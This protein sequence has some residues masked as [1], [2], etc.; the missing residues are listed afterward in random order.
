M[1]HQE[2]EIVVNHREQLAYLLSEAAEIEH[3]LMCCYLYASFSLKRHIDEGVTA[4]ELEAINRWRITLNE[5]AREE[6]VHLALVSNLCTAIG[7][8]PHLMRPNLPVASGYHPSGISLSLSRLDEA[9]IDHFVYM[10]RPEGVQLPD[11][12]GYAKGDYERPTLP[13]RLM[14]NAQDYATVGHLYR[15]ILDGC[16][17]LCATLGEQKLFCGDPRGQVDQK[18]FALDGLFAITDLASAERA[19]QL[20][21]TQGEGASVSSS[22]GHYARFVQLQREYQELR[23]ARPDFDPARPVARNPVMRKPPSPEDRVYIDD[24]AAAR[25][26]DFANALYT[27]IVRLL[28]RVFGTVEE[29]EAER[30]MLAGLTVDL[31]HA[32]TVTSNVLTKMP[33]SAAHPG[34]RAGITFAISRSLDTLPQHEAARRLF[35]ERAHELTARCELLATEVSADLAPVADRLRRLR[36]RLSASPVSAPVPQQIST[37]ISLPI[38]AEPTV[39]GEDGIER[40]TGKRITLAFEA[41]R[42]IHSRH[43]V[44][45]GPDVFL[46]NVPGAWIHPDAASADTVVAIAQM[47]PSGAITYERTDGEPNERVPL[48]NVARVREN[49][50]YAFTADL[51]LDGREP[52][53]RATLCRCG[54]SQNKPFCD[55]SHNGIKFSATGEPAT[56]STEPLAERGGALAVS[57]QPNGPLFVTGNLEICAGTGRILHRVTSA[58]LCRCGGS[59]KKP[60]CDG[61]HA[62]IGFEAD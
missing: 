58:K 3:G 14:P 22:A 36:D 6:M 18:I 34:V 7:M 46:A 57:P 60:F 62:R 50:P 39:K 20:I 28:G 49:G 10:E 2:P 16:R 32:M 52:M 19:I 17:S 51:Q 13:G 12:E 31:M 23:K 40:V 37:Q 26:L 45:N 1:N 42:C 29:S 56:I 27:M 41:K 33:A 44:L 21:L 53:I 38:T 4:L 59:A 5:V 8:A 24:A 55:G 61:T 25:V 11:G 48:V 47:C 54:A 15:G 43:C 30:R 9:T 35:C